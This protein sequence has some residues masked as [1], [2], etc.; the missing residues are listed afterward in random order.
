MI[1]WREIEVAR[2]GFLYVLVHP[3]NPRLHKIGITTLRPEQRLAQHNSR[4]EEHAGRI[5]KE[6]GQKWELKAYFDVA[7]TV[8]AE[9]VFWSATGWT[10]IPYRGGV[11]VVQMDWA[12]V[13]VGLDAV[14]TQRVR[15]QPT[16]LPWVPAYNAWM[17]KHLEGRG[18]ILLGDVRSKYGKSNFRCDNG[19]QW[20]TRPTDV[21]EGRGCPE[22]GMGT[23]TPDA[24]QQ[25]VGATQLSL[26]RHSDKPGLIKIGLTHG[27]P[28]AWQDEILSG[29]WEVHRYRRVDDP[30]L[31]VQVIWQLLDRTMPDDHEPIAIDLRKA[32]Q[33][34]RELIPRMREQ[35]AAR[36]TERRYGPADAEPE[37][38]G[39]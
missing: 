15:P 17:N 26:L 25:A 24:V 23:K 8:L 21:A 7:D 39:R 3:S 2:P 35:I 10:D 36:S 12:L 4:Y 33:A 14:R 20:R 19:H 32:E 9:S 6:T 38:G 18:I 27:G 31:A 37:T 30:A 29:G 11:E 5:V 22:C 1:M 34:F 16:T 28:H 13:Q